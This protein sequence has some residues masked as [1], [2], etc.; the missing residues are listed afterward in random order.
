[1]PE[2]SIAR[3][4]PKEP[5]TLVSVPEA[6]VHKDRCLSLLDDKVRVSWQSTVVQAESNASAEQTPAQNGLWQRVLAANA[7][8]HG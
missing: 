5:A 4:K 7:A 3:R 2:V 6:S 1:M 8:H